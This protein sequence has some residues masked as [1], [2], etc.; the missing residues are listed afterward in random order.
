[1]LAAF[2]IWPDGWGPRRMRCGK[3]ED[4]RMRLAYL[5]RGLVRLALLGSGTALFLQG[6]DPTLR[7]T[8][9]NG[10]I[11]LSTSFLASFLRAAIEVAQEATTS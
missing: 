8:T 5:N 9:E 1:M 3:E 11:T 7:A 2:A 4:D 10:L 6:C